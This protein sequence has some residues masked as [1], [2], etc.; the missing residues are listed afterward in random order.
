MYMLIHGLLSLA[1]AAVVVWFQ[2]RF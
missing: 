2:L 1:S